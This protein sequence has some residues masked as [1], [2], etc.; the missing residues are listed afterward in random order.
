MYR[1]PRALALI[2]CVALA[3][4]AVAAPAESPVKRLGKT[5]VQYRDDTVKAVLSWRY[6]NQTFEKEP[7][8][9]LELAFAAEGNAVDLNREDVSLMTPDGERLDLPSQKR[10]S[11]GLPDVRWVLL[12][13]SVAREPV[14]GYFSR[15]TMEQR[16]P[17][18]AVPGEQIVQDEICG[19]LLVPDPRR[20]LLRVADRDVETGQLHARPEEQE[21][22]RRAAVHP[23][24]RR[25][26][27]GREA[28]G[29]KDRDLVVTASGRAGRPRRTRPL[30]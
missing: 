6:A 10:L 17:F 13:A 18:F 8:L 29:R 25:A 19:G 16:L 11:Q 2:A 5:V 22:G 9:L 26:E 12:K 15:Q 28:R 4:A 24:R 27:E 30:R 20:P 14:T 3:G 7:W 21:D 1:T 23:S